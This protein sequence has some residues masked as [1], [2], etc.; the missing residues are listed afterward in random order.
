MSFKAAATFKYSA[1]ALVQRRYEWRVVLFYR[2]RG[3]AKHARHVVNASASTELA[4][5]ERVLL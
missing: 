4:R 1:H 3:I 5:W 2:F